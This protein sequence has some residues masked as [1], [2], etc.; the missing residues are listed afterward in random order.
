MKVHL[1]DGTYELF[2]AY[3]G[4]PEAQMPG[5]GEIGAVRGLMRSL[6][7]L[8]AEPDVTH[9]AVAFDHTVESFRNDLYA[10]YKTGQGLDPALLAQFGPAEEA[11]LALGVVTWPMVEFEAD[12]AIATAAAR[13]AREPAVSEI[14]I[15]SPDK[16]LAQCVRGERVVGRDRQ[17]R[18][19]IDEAAVV[20]KF[21]VRPT[22]IPDWLAL[23]GD[24]ADGFPGI[25]RWGAR[26]AAAVL[27]V[28]EHIESIPEDPTVWT[29]QVRGA[30]ALADSLNARRT[31]A[32]LFKVL[33]T[34]R[35]DVPLPVTL[36]DL[37]WR[38]ARLGE[39]ERF[40]ARIGDRS[41]V[42]RAVKVHERR[43]ATSF[44]AA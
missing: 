2:R 12:D 17:R 37:R 32:A 30:R 23:V 28:Y 26:S 34:L 27:A 19:T 6:L 4:S 1:I 9:A 31:Q 44:P 38:G 36:D 13:F 22:S 18:K 3:F 16:D 33:A 10:G 41:I 43:S 15:C 21:G 20:A 42:E 14:V 11:T 8:L 39:L 40:A 5:G 25:P 24:S 35:T 29:A 7:A